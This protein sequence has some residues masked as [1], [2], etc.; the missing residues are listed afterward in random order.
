MSTPPRRIDTRPD[1]NLFQLEY[2]ALWAGVLADPSA[3]L[4]KLVLADWLEETGDPAFAFALRWCVARR[5]WPGRKA[6]RRCEWADGWS[7]DSARHLP[8]PVYVS[9]DTSFPR[10]SSRTYDS[11]PK[12]VRALGSALE[13]VRLACLTDPARPD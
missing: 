8:T 1:F 11:V 4:P 9:L 5:K 10:A 7:K 12:A 2:D 13:D 6:G 3:G